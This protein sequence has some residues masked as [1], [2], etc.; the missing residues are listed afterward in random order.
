MHVCAT[1]HRCSRPPPSSQPPSFL[2]P[3]N[4][5]PAAEGSRTAHARQEKRLNEV[6]GGGGG[7]DAGGAATTTATTTQTHFHTFETADGTD[8]DTSLS[9]V[10]EK[11]AAAAAAK[12]ATAAKDDAVNTSGDKY[13]VICSLGAGLYTQWQSRVVRSRSCVEQELC[14]WACPGVG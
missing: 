6:V 8:A 7:G 3:L 10:K 5:P 9:A 14:V 13:H 12:A 1:G 2:P 4:R 11:E